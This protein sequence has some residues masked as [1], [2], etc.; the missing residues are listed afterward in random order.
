MIE[1]QHLT[2]R[3]LLS[4]LRE[5]DAA[6]AAESKRGDAQFLADAGFELSE[7]LDPEVTY[8]AIA[9]LMLPRRAAWCIVDVLETD[10]VIRRVAVIHPDP[11]KHAAARALSDYWTPAAGDPIGVPALGS[12]RSSI[13]LGDPRAILAAA[14]RVSDATRVVEWLGTG[15]V[16]IVPLLSDDQLLGAITF[17]RPQHD[18]PYTADEI[19]HS[20]ALAARCARALEGAHRFAMARASA[21]S[22]EASRADAEANRVDAEA[23]RDVAQTENSAKDGAIAMVSHELRSPLGAIAN[24]VQI[25]QLEICGPVTTMQ[26]TVL[27]R[28]A[29]SHEHV[30]S[31]V[32][33][34]L[35]LHRG[36][37]GK[38]QFEIVPVS[39]ATAI[40]KAVD[41]AAWQFSQARV[42]LTLHLH[43]AMGDLYT[44]SRKFTQIIV[45]L[46]SNASKYTPAGG[47]V[48]LSG[49]R[50]DGTIS[51]QVSDNG[52]GI[53][54]A[55]HEAVFE[56]FVQ[57][58]DARYAH[59]GG[60]GLGLAISRQ[61]ARGLGGDLTLQSV[62]G[63]GSTFTLTI[64]D[65]M[66]NSITADA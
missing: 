46:L 14:E 19:A 5:Q 13:A 26:R 28:I 33:Q 63:S 49:A 18:A 58:R 12:A 23:A 10:G 11:L 36:A 44:D 41:M 56:P 27:G 65:T 53:A 51:I 40:D 66:P 35:D 6:D 64:P 54:A 48:T 55:H 15:P 1:L 29:A 61:L 38:M 47:R 3:I 21:A 42:E 2:E 9:N 24:N 31:L 39:V 57:V 20:E 43:E 25:L 59:A 37:I 62:Q 30:M 50:H 17:V 60:A 7:S 45:N 8:N 22:A 16:L 34:L 4:A 52:I 32:D